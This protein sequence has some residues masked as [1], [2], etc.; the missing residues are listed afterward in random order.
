MICDGRNHI[1]AQTLARYKYYRSLT[2]RSVRASHCMIR[3]KSRFIAPV[4]QSLFGL[5][6][7]LNLA[8]LFLQPTTNCLRSPLIGSA[9]RFLWCETPTPK[10]AAHRRQRKPNGKPHFD[11]LHYC[12]PRPKPKGQ[13]QLFWVMVHYRLGNMC[14]LPGKKRASFWSSSLSSLQCPLST[15]PVCFHPSTQ[16]LACNS[17]KP[18]HLD[19]F[20][21]A[22]HSLHALDSDILLYNREK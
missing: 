20:L 18:R 12:L 8:I 9:N 17:E 3:A 14:R 21:A 22:Q 2:T 15:F 10:I 16:S 5:G 11:Q 19:L 7:L 4:N 6:L 1:A 13:L